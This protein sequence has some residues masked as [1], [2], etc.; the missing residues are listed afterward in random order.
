MN[1]Q[2]QEA[3]QTNL[4]MDS[5]IATYESYQLHKHHK[6]QQQYNT[7][8]AND[9]ASTQ[10]QLASYNY[11]HP[12]KKTNN[13]TLNIRD[14]QQEEERREDVST[15]RQS[16][17]MPTKLSSTHSTNTANNQPQSVRFASSADNTNMNN[18]NA[19]A[20]NT[21]GGYNQQ[22]VAIQNE[23]NKSMSSTINTYDDYT[24]GLNSYANTPGQ[25]QKYAV[26]NTHV[27][28]TRSVAS[29]HQ[30]QQKLVQHKEIKKV[31]PPIKLS[32]KTTTLSNKLISPIKSKVKMVQPG[33]LFMRMPINM[34]EEELRFS[35]G[36]FRYVSFVF[37][38]CAT[39]CFWVVHTSYYHFDQN[40]NTTSSY[41]IS[42]SQ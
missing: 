18:N 24:I 22:Q 14:V 27:P 38:G 33:R 35:L 11:Y 13:Q 9:N 39:R 42:H 20:H 26:P 37:M 34:K 1:Y 36:E 4:T 6:Q 2:N 5:T 16:V 32:Q 15:L 8:T 7:N 29:N 10:A 40:T 23:I 3:P 41:T 12:T 30:P 17:T 21:T 28:N 25:K 19:N 31:Y